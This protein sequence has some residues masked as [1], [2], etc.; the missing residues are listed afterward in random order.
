MA[1]DLSDAA[2]LTRLIQGHGR[3][4]PLRRVSTE[5]AS[6]PLSVPQMHDANVGA[7][8]RVLD[9]AVAAGVKRIVYV[10]TANAFG[11]T[12]GQLVDETYRRDEKRGFVSWYD[13]TKYRAHQAAESADRGGSTDRNRDADPGVRPERPL[14]GERA[15]GDGLQG[16]AA[17]RCIPFDRAGVG[18][19]PRPRR[20][21]RG[22]ARPGPHRRVLR[23][24][25]RSASD[26]R[27]RGDRCAARRSQ[28]AATRPCRRRCCVCL[29]R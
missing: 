28:A 9:A 18:A 29:R 15:A 27:L 12:R 11:D 20:R 23:A 26:R 14:A 25:W 24:G 16:D 3:R 10:S 4:H 6:S 5:S 7:T 8:E 22:G 1:S 19:R 17:F 13:E 21:H 2:A